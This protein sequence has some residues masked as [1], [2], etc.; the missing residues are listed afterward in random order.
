MRPGLD[1]TCDET[2]TLASFAARGHLL[3]ESTLVLRRHRGVTGSVTGG[4]IRQRRPP[5]PALEERES[6]SLLRFAGGGLQHVPQLRGRKK[7]FLQNVDFDLSGKPLPDTGRPRIG[8]VSLFGFTA[9]LVQ[10]P[11][12]SPYLPQL[13]GQADLF[14]QGP[15]L[16]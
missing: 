1:V 6:R 4:E 8:A 10:L 9:L 2:F 7:A 14:C 16:A 3:I 11:E 15:C 5:E 12:G 13:T